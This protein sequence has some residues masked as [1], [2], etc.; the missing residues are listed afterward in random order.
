MTDKCSMW[1]YVGGT[2]QQVTILPDL[3]SPVCVLVRRLQAEHIFTSVR[4]VHLHSPAVL[5]T[6]DYS[7][8]WCL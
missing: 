3:W 6:D 7:D 8:E 2:A 1:I 4:F 5:P